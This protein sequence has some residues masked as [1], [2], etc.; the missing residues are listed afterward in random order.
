MTH[1]TTLP[2]DAGSPLRDI[3]QTPAVR[4]IRRRATHLATALAGRLR[5]AVVA[6][7]AL[8]TAAVT[9]LIGA[10][11][12]MAALVRGLEQVVPTWVAYAITAC[13]LLLSAAAAIAL[14]TWA[15]LRAGR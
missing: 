8:V 13:L 11:F 3:L 12:A 7:L 6:G 15:L 14:G 10:V 5:L 9:A 1:Q 4:Q 2:T